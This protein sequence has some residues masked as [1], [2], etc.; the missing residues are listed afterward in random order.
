MKGGFTMFYGGVTG[1]VQSRRYLKKIIEIKI[2]KEFW[3]E[4]DREIV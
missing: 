4:N 1:S 2:M 3:R